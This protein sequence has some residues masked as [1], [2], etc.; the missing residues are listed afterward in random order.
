MSDRQSLLNASNKFSTGDDDDNGN[1]KQLFTNSFSDWRRCFSRKGSDNKYTKLD[2]DTEHSDKDEPVGIFRLFQFANRTDFVLMFIAACF[3]MLHTIC[4]LIHLLLFGRLTGLFA[5][6]SFGD[7]CD[8]RHQNTIGP[9]KNNNTYSQVIELNRFNNDSSYKLRH[10][11]DVILSSTIATS[12]PSFREKVMNIVHW[13]FIIGAVELLASSIEN[14]IWTISVKRQTSR[15]SVSLFRS[16]VQ[17]SI[18]YMD[19]KQTSQLSAKLFDWQLTLIMLCLI[20]LVIGS[21]FVFS[22]LTAKEAM[23]ELMTYSKAGQIV[24]E[25]FSSL[26]TVLS[27]NGSKFEQKRYD[28]ELYSTRWSNIRKGAVF[29]IFNGWSSLIIY[30]MYS[31]GFIFGSLLMSYKDDHTLNISDIFVVKARGA[32]PSVFRLIDEGNDASVNEIDIWK[33]DTEAIYNI[34]GDIE[35]DNINFSYPSRRDVPVLGN[36]SLIAR[37]GQ[38]TALV[39]SSGCGKS[40]CISLFLRYY[41]PS[42]GRIMI[43]GRPITDYHVQQLRQNIGVVSQEPILFGMSIYE[44]I[45][46]G[47]VNATQAEIEQAAREA[48]AHNFIMQLP[49]K[50][51]TLVG[52][53]GIQL[54]GGEKQR[55]ALARALVKQPTFLLLDEA[56]SALDNVSEKIVQEAL[57]RACKGRTTIIIA[58]RLATIQNAHHIYVLDNGSVI[59]QGT[60]E[61]LMAKEGGKYQAM[62]KLQQ[63][64]RINDDQDDMMSIQKTTEED[65]KSIFE[66]SCLLSDNQTVD[67]NKQS[68]KLFRQ[69]FIFLRLLSMNSPEWITILIGCIAC[70]LNGAAQPLF[71]FLLTKIV[72]AFKYC[73]T[74]ERR[75]HVLIT[76]FLFLL[77]GALVWILRFFQYT[78]FAIAGSKLTQRIRSKAFACLLRQEV[79]YF[80]RPENSSGAICARLSSDASAVQEMASTRLGDMCEAFAWSFIGILFGSFISWQLT[81]IV[82]G[83]LFCFFLVIYGEVRLRLQMAQQSGHIIGR[84][85]M[86][87]VETIHNMRTIKQLSIE[88]EV[89]R[90]YSELIH[91]VFILSWKPSI[92]YS[93]SFGIYWIL[94]VYTLAFVYWCA[95]VLFEK[96]KLA[97]NRIIMACAFAIFSMQTLRLIGMLSSSIATSV[98]AIKTFFDLFDRKPAIDNTSTEGQELVDFRGEIKFDQVKF[99]YPARPTSIILNKFQLNIK[100]S[101]RVAL[102]GTSGCGKS[103]IIQLLERFYDVKSGRILIDGIDIRQLNLHWVRSQFG[104]VNQEPNLFDLTIA[105]N[106]AYGLENVPMEDIINA[107]RKANIHQF[108][109][110]LPQSY[111]TKVGMKGSF[112]SG[113]EKQRIAIARVLLRRPKVLLLDEATSTMDSH[114]EQIVQKALEQAQTEDSSRTSLIIAHRLSTIRS[115]DL[116]CVLDRGHIV[117]S[118]THTELIQQHGVYYRMLAQNNLQ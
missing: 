49:D 35:F 71:A 54:S 47:K 9:T 56:T 15:M 96:D 10:N 29:G 75:R 79:A 18:P 83:P 73:S 22:Q 64:E 28:R 46:F 53:R 67:M 85:S 48:N 113:G 118:G 80:D 86:L 62:V 52:E 20:P 19:T 112:L 90:Q 7:N 108:I 44:N 72:E 37:A 101:Q 31:I 76:S 5:T 107:A 4:N 87:V 91:E 115:C 1:K 2:D 93:I 88:K 111:E 11:I 81:L 103:T 116:I 30:L 97:A 34:N 21:S 66:R 63:M 6:E 13:L 114:N 14:F 74:S 58:H 82:F 51:E 16:I 59:E 105:E 45:R 84:A 89:L 24:Q 60:H 50:Y 94:G 106:I 26:R 70:V 43:D 100:A 109:E 3:L 110:Q 40:T 27:L 36:L 39:G 102:V 12:M 77:L 8:Y 55:I 57:D 33:E 78:A 41:E 95:L 65:E 68:S 42:S 92:V 69:K 104:L 61:T 99:I 25:V 17:R 98:S 23:N 32:A 38:T 117:E